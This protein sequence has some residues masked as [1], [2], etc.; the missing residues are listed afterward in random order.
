M[1]E[2]IRIALVNEGSAG[3]IRKHVLNIAR[4]LDSKRFAVTVILAKRPGYE[5][6]GDPVEEL[7]EAGIPFLTVPMVRELSPYSDLQ[8]W[9]KL[10]RELRNFDVV[11]AHSAK[12]GFLARAICKNL[13][14]PCFYSPHVFPFQRTTRLKAKLY[15]ALERRA[16]PWTTAFIVNSEKE[17]E[18]AIGNGLATPER[19]HL[20]PNAITLPS[21]LPSDIRS[22]IRYQ[23][24]TPANRI[25]FTTI[26][27]LVAYKGQEILIRAFSTLERKDVELWIVG[28]GEDA[29]KLAA[30]TAKLGLTDRVRFLGYRRD[31][32][33]ILAASDCFVLAS[34]NEGCPYTVIEA[35]AMQ[36]PIIA[37]AVQGIVDLLKNPAYCRLVPWNDTTALAGAI[38]EF[39]TAPFTGAPLD[40]L[41]KELFDLPGQ[42][43]RLQAIYEQAA[44]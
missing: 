27:R 35:L 32:F 33:A 7:A 5:S 12:A 38:Q 36:K 20:V 25:V 9:G 40:S 16:A 11:H 2:R 23:I 37:T 1:Q 39:L 3:G 30:L 6:E 44:L 15:L 8:S 18:T 17:Q 13:H 43:R 21:P 42:I 10:R 28:E 34:R 29:S 24:G 19:I 41:S 31:V 26:G 4:N 22:E 14:I